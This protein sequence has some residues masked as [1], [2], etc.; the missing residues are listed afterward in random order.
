MAYYMYRDVN[1]LW[2]WRLLAG[3]NRNIA[4]SG[5][6]YFNEA[7]CLHAINLVKGSSAA[8]VYKS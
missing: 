7:D 1:N 8:P 6:E 4:N 3:N 5:E 2:R